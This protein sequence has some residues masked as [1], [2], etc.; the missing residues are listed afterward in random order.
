[1]MQNLEEVPRNQKEN[2][3]I[4]TIRGIQGCRSQNLVF[5]VLVPPQGFAAY[6]SLNFGFFGTSSRFCNVLLQNLEEIP[7]NQK[8]ETI[9]G[10]RG[11]RSQ[12]FFC[13][14]WYLLEV[15]QHFGA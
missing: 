5:F 14:F 8:F 6:W 1:M 4:E 2:Q 11:C 9:R 15:L 13:F 7:Q 3:K 12:S 10:I